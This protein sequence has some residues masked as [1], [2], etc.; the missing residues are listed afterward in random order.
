MQFKTLGK[1]GITVSRLCLGCMTY[2]GGEV[3]A[4][5]LGTRGWHVGKD[6]AREHFKLALDAGV[7]F[8]DTADVYSAGL[9]EEITGSLLKE[10]ASRDDIVV[11]TKVHGPMGPGP[12]RRGLSRKH[13]LEACENSLRRL[14]MD[15]VDLYQIHRWDPATPIEVTLDALDALVRAGKVR[16][17]GASSMAAWQLSKA[18]YTAKEN[19]WHRFA[20]MQNHYNLVYREEEREMIPLCLDQGLAIIPWSPLA[21]GFLTGSRT[22]EGGSTQR[23]QADGFAKN[24]YYREDDFAVADAVA[25][26]AKQRGASAAQ[27]ACAWVLQAPG[28]TAPIIGAT[29]PQHLKELIAAVD[30]KLSAEEVAALEKPYRPHPILG[31]AQPAPKSMTATVA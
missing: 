27:V 10:M 31:H 7:N 23:A 8:F 3:P 19:G 15:Y 25:E 9:S 16:H 14:G 26:V 4:W 18:L 24:L 22:R 17:L 30:L 2:G 21:R 12:N 28:V 1:T 5:A 11:A 13:I 6:D 20:T 29:K